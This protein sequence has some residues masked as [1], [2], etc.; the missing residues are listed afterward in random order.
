MSALGQSRHFDSAPRTSAFP[1]S[2][3]IAD[4]VHQVRKVP[5]PDI[6]PKVAIRSEA[7]LAW[8]YRQRKNAA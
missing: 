3:D 7:D 2:A 4:R 5:T 8:R 6:V 1:R